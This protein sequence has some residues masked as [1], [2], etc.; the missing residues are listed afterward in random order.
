MSQ[1]QVSREVKKLVNLGIIQTSEAKKL[2]DGTWGHLTYT[3]LGK[4]AWKEPL[5]LAK[6][7]RS[8]FRVSEPKDCVAVGQHK[9]IQ[10]RKSKET[11]GLRALIRKTHNPETEDTGGFPLGGSISGKGATPEG[12]S[13]L[14]R[15]L[16]V[17]L[18]VGHRLD[19]FIGHRPRAAAGRAEKTAEG[20]AVDEIVRRQG[21]EEQA[22]AFLDAVTR[23]QGKEFFPR[24]TSPHAVVAK[25]D[26]I[27]LALES[28]PVSKVP[29]PKVRFYDPNTK[30]YINQ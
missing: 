26:D 8:D 4:D 3:L 21:G 13:I 27:L 19:R 28:S 2:S 14:N 22:L 10:S 11:I 16:T 30:T 9:D 24:A 20:R 23:N 6:K 12:E 15:A 25:Y 29:A 7:R 5:K 18:P 1:R 17:M